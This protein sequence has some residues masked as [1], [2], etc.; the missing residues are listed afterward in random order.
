MKAIRIYKHGKSDVLSIDDLDIPKPLAGEILVKI[1]TAALNHLDLFV[2][3]GI[4][5]VP[6]PII[7]GSDAAGEVIET[8]ENVTRFKKGNEVINV[9]F[10]INPD[11]PLIKSNNENLSKN[12]Q[13]PDI[14][15]NP[16]VARF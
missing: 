11:E 9:P 5:G 16:G 12:Y 7:M 15:I 1:K 14:P 2:R 6:L 4:P 8:G 10:R 13:I 3:N